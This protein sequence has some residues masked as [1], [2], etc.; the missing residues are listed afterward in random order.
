MEQYRNRV[1]ENLL[2]LAKFTWDY[3]VLEIG[4]FLCQI[5]KHYKSFILKWSPPKKEHLLTNKQISFLS[6]FPEKIYK[7]PG[8]S[9][10]NEF[11]V[12]KLLPVFTQRLGEMAQECF[13]HH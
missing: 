6:L 10:L 5:S 3:P 2:S 12:D 11:S 13:T 9:I 1:R 4:A 7:G 8:N